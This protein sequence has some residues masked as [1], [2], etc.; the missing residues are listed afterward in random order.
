[1]SRLEVGAWRQHGPLDPVLAGTL[2]GLLTTW[3]TFTPCFLWIFF[4]A[5]FVEALRANKALA[6]ALG[7]VT[8]AVVGVILNLAVWFALQVLF[9]GMICRMGFAREDDLHGSSERRQNVR[10]SFRVRENQFRAFV[11]RKRAGEA[12]G[13]RRR[14]QERAGRDHPGG[15]YVLCRPQ[16]AGALANEGDK[17]AA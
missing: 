10:Q 15:G 14:V 8:A 16:L 5:P 6:A 12:N 4:G 11:F 13:E 9:A 2:G 17:V 7:A 3:V 1:M